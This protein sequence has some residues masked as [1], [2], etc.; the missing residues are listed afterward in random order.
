MN[1]LNRS[2]Q[3]RLQRLKQ[4]AAVWEGDQ[5][6]LPAQAIP[7]G[8]SDLQCVLW[9]DEAQS[10]V[11]AM[12]MVEAGAGPEVVVRT[13]LKAIETP[14]S[15]A[16]PAR[17]RR[18][19]VRSREL[20]FYLRGVLQE[21]DITVDYA[22]QLPLIDDIF[23]GLEQS[24]NGQLPTLPQPAAE[25]VCHLAEQL[26]R[27]AAWEFLWDHQVIALE[28]QQW[29]VGTLHATVMGRL[30][31]EQGVIFYRSQESLLRF[32]QQIAGRQAGGQG[33]E[34]AFLSQDCLFVLFDDAD[35]AEPEEIQLARSL[36]WRLDQVYPV[37]GSL[38]PLEGGRP[39]LYDEE[40]AVLHCALTALIRFLKQHRRQLHSGEFPAIRTQYRI[41]AL[42]QASEAAGDESSASAG[43]LSQT[44]ATISA[45]V[46][47]LPELADHLAMMGEQPAEEDAFTLHEDLLPGDALLTIGGVSWLLAEYLREGI[48]YYQAAESSFPEKSDHLPVLLVQTSRP[49]AL[50]L[51]QQLRD[52]GGVT[53]VCFNPGESLFGD[54]YELGIL[55]T[56]DGRLHLFGEFEQDDPVHEQAKQKWNQRCRKTEGYCGL[57]IA[58]GATGQSRGNPQPKHMLALFESKS[59]S[60]EE[61]GIGVLQAIPRLDL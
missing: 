55:Q 9:V 30:G 44:M 37:F 32:R 15:P 10:T 33:T 25:P 51:I 53:G 57:V 6:A 52:A 2:T 5:R 11:R 58:M 29:E 27:L 50:D 56:G 36:G 34:E 17:P 16:F 4:V 54:K 38:H 24:L 8:S 13:L 3:R 18:V 45:I 22:P 61:L 43:P 49:K 7:G 21:L 23:S 31:L 60:S 1:A 47:T 14:Q 26:W 20:Q 48:H 46:E 41:P 28:I 12:D 35:D 59:L 42:L 39:F 19:L 40:A